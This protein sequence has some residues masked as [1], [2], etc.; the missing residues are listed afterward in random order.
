MVKYTLTPKQKATL[1][2]EGYVIIIREGKKIKV[3]SSMAGLKEAPEKK[4]PVEYKLWGS[5][6]SKESLEALINKCFYS[7]NWK[8]LPDNS[9]CNTSYSAERNKDINTRYRV[10]HKKGRWRFE[11]IV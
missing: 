11:S 5:S 4:N 9:L 8:I 2:K 3:T 6:G 1:I 10:L 7:T